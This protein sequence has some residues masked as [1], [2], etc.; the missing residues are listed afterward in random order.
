MNEVDGRNTCLIH[1]THTEMNK[2]KHTGNEPTYI[3]D[4]QY[5]IVKTDTQCDVH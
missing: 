2:G 5:V 4:I 1:I 3:I